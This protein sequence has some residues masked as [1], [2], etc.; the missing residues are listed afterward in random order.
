MNG[1]GKIWVN[2][3]I[4]NP[5]LADKSI[6]ELVAA[7]PISTSRFINN[8]LKAILDFLTSDDEPIGKVTH[9]YYRREYQGRGLQHLHFQIWV[10]NAPVI[11][12]NNSDE[13]IKFI[14]K[15][16]TC[17]VPNKALSPILY[18]RVTKCD[19]PSENQPSSHFQICHFGAL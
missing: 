6:S 4:V 11:G 15:Y 18:N 19:C 12:V 7:D 8:K 16:C 17:N 5:D 3:Y 9:Y 1:L 2:I 14:S 10:E 13:I